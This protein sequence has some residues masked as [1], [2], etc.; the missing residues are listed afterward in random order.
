MKKLKELSLVEDGIASS[1]IYRAI[2]ILENQ[3][4]N[5]ERLE[6]MLKHRYCIKQ[7]VIETCRVLK[8]LKDQLTVLVES[9]KHW[10]APK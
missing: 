2:E 10:E 1:G 3:L 9:S 4:W 5:Y 6:D 8:E 7:E